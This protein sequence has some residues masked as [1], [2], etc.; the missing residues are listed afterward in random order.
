MFRTA[1]HAAAT[2]CLL[3]IAACIG[4]PAF[5]VE[6]VITAP[7]T[8]V[9]LPYGDWIV[10]AG[11]TVTAVLLPV[12]IAVIMGLLRS[13][14]PVLGLFVSQTLVERLVRNAADYGLNA[15]AGAVKG[16]KLDVPTGS[17]VIAK[18]MQRAV[19]QAP[20]WLLEKAG[21]P[22]GVGEKVF[23]L[24][25]LDEKATAA[26]TLAPALDAVPGKS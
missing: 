15:V 14:V 25:H 24:L 22:K 5:A 20:G 1:F 16:Q 26:N 19:D 4:N 8:A 13:Y 21:G 12:L 10:G 6:A 9:V 23:R 3:V 17:A 18:A 7:A 11:Q 2:G